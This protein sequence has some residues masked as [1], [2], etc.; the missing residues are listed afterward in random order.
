MSEFECLTVSRELCSIIRPDWQR[1]ILVGECCKMLLRLFTIWQAVKTRVLLSIRSEACVGNRCCARRVL[2]ATGK[3][4]ME[5]DSPATLPPPK[6]VQA[7]SY[8][9]KVLPTTPVY[10]RTNVAPVFALMLSTAYRVHYYLFSF[11]TFSSFPLPFPGLATSDI[12]VPHCKDV[13][14]ITVRVT[15][16]CRSASAFG[17]IA[18]CSHG[19]D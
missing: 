16:L 5:K 3:T 8:C 10:D 9:R 15:R 19:S 2:L 12:S 1:I 6:G 14:N 18:T 13:R 17:Q 7:P 11:N 4:Y